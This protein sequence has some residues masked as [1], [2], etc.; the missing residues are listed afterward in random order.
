MDLTI[1]AGT[2]EASRNIY[3]D[4]FIKA[5]FTLTFVYVVFASVS[6]PTC[7]KKKFIRN[8]YT[9]SKFCFKNIILKLL[10]FACKLLYLKKKER[11]RET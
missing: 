9:Y 2:L 6:F 11:E 7:S 8:R 1:W 5:G 3:A 4:S 10:L